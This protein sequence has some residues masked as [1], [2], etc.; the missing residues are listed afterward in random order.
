MA[1]QE[2]EGTTMRLARFEGVQEVPRHG[3]RL[4]AIAAVESR[5]PAAG[6]VL[7]EIH[8]V[9]EPLQHSGHRHADLGKS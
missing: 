3:A 1:V 8:L 7:R 5:L 4:A 9:A 2:P 6:L